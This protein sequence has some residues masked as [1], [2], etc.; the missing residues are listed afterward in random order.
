MTREAFLQ[1]QACSAG[2]PHPWKHQKISE[3]TH[4]TVLAEALVATTAMGKKGVLVHVALCWR[5]SVCAALGWDATVF[6]LSANRSRR[7]PAER[8][9]VK[10]KDNC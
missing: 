2:V 1:T 10:N 5:S 4:T 8:G 6:M 7:S 9:G 3:P